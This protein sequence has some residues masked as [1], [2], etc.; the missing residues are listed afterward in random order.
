[1]QITQTETPKMCQG[2]KIAFSNI[3][4]LW[5]A[6]FKGLGWVGGVQEGLNTNTHDRF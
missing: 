5:L 3:M 4:A 1:M 6:Y 2:L